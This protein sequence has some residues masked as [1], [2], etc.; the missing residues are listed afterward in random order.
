[1]KTMTIYFIFASMLLM[2]CDDMTE[3]NKIK[4][5]SIHTEIGILSK[6]ISLPRQPVSVKWKTERYHQDSSLLALL[7]F[8]EVDYNYIVE[9]SQTFGSKIN[10][11][12]S[13]EIY[14]KWLPDDAKSG[15]TVKPFSATG[16]TAYE[17]IGI[18][19]LKANLFANRD[20]SPYLQGR[21]TPLK[22]GYILISLSTM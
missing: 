19:Q 15:I 13:P 18:T 5:E 4:P 10:R 20:L 12:M 21:I 2:G 11:I 7:K 22:N 9:N 6:L 3:N 16:V 1:M 14:D 8:K 17:L